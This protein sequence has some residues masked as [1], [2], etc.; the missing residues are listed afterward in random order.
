MEYLIAIIS[1]MLLSSVVT[2]ILL[3]SV[4]QTIIQTLETQLSALRDT[5]EKYIDQNTAYFNSAVY[6][7]PAGMIPQVAATPAEELFNAPDPLIDVALEA[8]QL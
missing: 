4:Y 5:C 8:G 1:G 3:R 6:H 2:A 7:Q